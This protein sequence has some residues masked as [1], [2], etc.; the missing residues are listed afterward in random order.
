MQPMPP[1][2]R[3]S[4]YVAIFN[5]TASLFCLWASTVASPGTP[6]VVQLIL[7]SC[8]AVLAY[9]NFLRW[10][11]LGGRDWTAGVLAPYIRAHFDFM[12]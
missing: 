1:L 10:W 6:T 12:L 9:F 11:M 3:G 8:N 7:A 2:G 5:I 4:L